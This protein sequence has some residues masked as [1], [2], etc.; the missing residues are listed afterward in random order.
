MS[1]SA[2]LER[3]TGEN[4]VSNKIEIAEQKLAMEVSLLNRNIGLY[5]L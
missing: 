4:Q 3:S 2:R 5:D 1:H